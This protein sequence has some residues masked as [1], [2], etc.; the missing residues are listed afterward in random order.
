MDTPLIDI[1]QYSDYRMFLKDSYAAR[2]KRSK[3]FSYRSFAM[4]AGTAPSLLADII[5]GRRTLSLAVMEKFAKTLGLTDRETR[6]F[7]ALV[8]FVNAKTSSGKNE[9]FTEMS[10]LRRQSH[11][12]FLRPE[13][14]EFWSQWHH[15]AIREMTTLPGFKEDPE[16][17]ARHIHPH[18]TAA[19]ARK[20][21]DT[22]QELGLL[23]RDLRGR[24][25]PSDPAISSEYE[26]PNLVI[27]QFNQEM[28]AQGLTATD[29]FPPEQREIGGLTLGL[30]QI[31]YDR[32][33]QRIRIFKEE[34]LSMVVEDKTDSELVAQLNM[35]LF[36]LGSC[37]PLCKEKAE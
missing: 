15:A 22:L 25:I 36:P 6:Y 26:V 10:R 17:I 3:T 16:W 7:G 32:I 33:K 9:A 8:R 12:R 5:E 11:L 18:I 1:F 24:L 29:R 35:Q 14:Y 21:L 19:Q 2:K 31:C 28:I 37:I 34:I 30:S 4:K 13:Q 23:R 27:R 20:S